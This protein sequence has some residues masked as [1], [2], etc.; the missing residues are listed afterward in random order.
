MTRT[1]AGQVDTTGAATTLPRAIALDL[2]NQQVY[3]TNSQSNSIGF[4]PLPGSVANAGTF[5]TSTV[6]SG[7]GSATINQPVG[8]AVDQENDRL[9][10]TNGSG[11]SSNPERRLKVAALN[12]TTSITSTFFDISPNP[13]GGLRTPVIDGVANRIYW[14][15]GSD[16]ISFADLNGGGGTNLATGSAFKN[17]A[18][19]VAILKDPEP[20]GPPSVTGTPETGSTLTCSV[21][22][23][24]PD[25]PNAGLYRV[26]ESTG[27]S[28][29]LDG[30]PIGGATGATHT[31]TAAGEYRCIGSATNFAGTNT[32]E[33]APVT[34]TAAPEPVG[35][36]CA[37]SDATRVG[38]AGRDVLA[39]TAGRDV[40]AGLGGND[41]IRGL[42]GNDVLCGGVGS[43]R[44]IGGR[45]RDRLFGNAGRDTCRGGAKRDRARTCEVRRTI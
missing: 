31:P 12:G 3:W 14:G 2:E 39:G 6:T 4:A 24:A 44:L 40:I 18:D 26:P 25:Q 17:S 29:T 42:A 1:R 9:F 7:D 36:K 43:D 13:G 35:A 19:G 23:W 16:L 15:S 38:T 8:V 5:T 33:S 32:Q 34:V 41:T 20:V 45:G 10:W 21:A 22:A 27:F 28:W 11:D 30:A 37:G